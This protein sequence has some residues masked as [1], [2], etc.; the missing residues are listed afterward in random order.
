MHLMETSHVQV[1]NGRQVLLGGL[2]T[3]SYALEN[4][5]SIARFGDGELSLAFGANTFRG[6]VFHT[7]RHKDIPFQH[8]SRRLTNML[9]KILTQPVDGLLVCLNNNF[10]KQAYYYM[11]LDYERA[12]KGYI[13]RISVHKANDVGVLE[14]KRQQHQYRKWFRLIEKRSSIHIWGEATCFWLSMYYEEYAANKISEVLDLYRQLFNRRHILIVAPHTPLHGPSFKSLVKDKII[15]TP[16]SIHFIEIPNRDCFEYYDDILHAIVKYE[17]LDAVFIQ[18]GPTATA[19]TAELTER[20]GLVSYDV[21]SL[22]VSLYR[23][24][25]IHRVFF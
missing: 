25:V 11:V 5:L 20:Y 19:L 23:A 18:A 14:R 21:G 16:K 17:N 6:K 4:H 15:K 12:S 22:N 3:L 2:S 7:L 9:Y 1:R 24:A 8:N 10:L 13:Q